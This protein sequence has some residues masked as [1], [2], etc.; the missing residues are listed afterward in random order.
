MLF[1]SDSKYL[2]ECIDSILKQTYT[3]FEICIADDCSNKQE[4]LDTLK[5][6]ETLDSRVKVFYREK[7]GHISNAT[8]SALSIASGDFIGLLDND[9][10]LH[11]NAL[12]EVVHALNKNEN[13]DFIYSDED[14]LSL[15]GERSDPHFKSD[16]CLDKFYG[17]NF[18]CHFSV[19]RKSIIEAVG[20]FKIGVEGAQDFDLFLRITNKTDKIYHIPK[21]LYHWRMIPGSTA[22]DSSSKNYAGEAGKK[23]LLDLFNSKGIDVEIDVVVN[24]HY[25]VKYLMEKEEKIDVILYVS[26][27]NIKYLKE[28]ENKMKYVYYSNYRIVS[29]T[30]DYDGS[31]LTSL[32]SKIN[33]IKTEGNPVH[34]INEYLKQSDAVHFLFLQ[35]NYM[36][37]TFDSLELMAG[38]SQ[39]PEVGVVG[40]KVLNKRKRVIEYGYVINEF[41]KCI[42]TN[43][44]VLQN[45]YG[46]YGNLLV[47]S[48]YTVLE[49]KA[50]MISKDKLEKVNWLNESL[51]VNK[52]YYDLHV[53]MKRSLGRN[54]ILPKVMF[55]NNGKLNQDNKNDLPILDHEYIDKYY[56]ENLSNKKAFAIDQVE[57]KQNR[58]YLK[59]GA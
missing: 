37:S 24:T 57:I 10:V 48:N 30:K 40:A 14:K 2:S 59:R 22:L 1:R 18:I 7:N 33:F 23:G 9:D 50:F 49:N 31:V 47:P 17:G 4:T 16:F 39:Q 12:N 44:E 25:F 41:G 29:F 46:I 21:I 19:I 20:G 45:E 27:N 32:K 11:I 34:K 13:L 58:T 52:A 8:N 56:N 38:Y 42:P 15:E 43:D 53:K 28:L 55:E 54:V 6:Y 51:S 26:S 35:E 3:N 36:P 5:E